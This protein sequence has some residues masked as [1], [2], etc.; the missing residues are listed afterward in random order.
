MFGECSFSL[1]LKRSIFLL[2]GQILFPF[3]QQFYSLLIKNK[4]NFTFIIGN[5]A[6]VLT[7]ISFLPQAIQVIKT[8]DTKSISLPMYV[9]FIL[10]LILWLTYGILQND[11]PIILSN[12]VTISLASVI[13]FY[14]IKSVIRKDFITSK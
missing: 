6:A 13:L 10:G 7:S 2:F 14:K 12:I 5:I 1:I 8:K 4:M 11:F 3:L 9:L